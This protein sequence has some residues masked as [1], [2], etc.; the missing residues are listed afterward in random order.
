MFLIFLYIKSALA[1]G[2]PQMPAASNMTEQAKAWA[3]DDDAGAAKESKEQITSIQI[4]NE[5]IAIMRADSLILKRSICKVSSY[6]TE[7]ISVPLLRIYF[8]SSQNFVI[9]IT[10]VSKSKLPKYVNFTKAI[11]GTEFI[12]QAE[13]FIK[14]YFPHISAITREII[15]LTG[16]NHINKILFRQ[17]KTTDSNSYSMGIWHN[18]PYLQTDY[19]SGSSANDSLVSACLKLKKFK[20]NPKMIIA[21]TDGFITVSIKDH[22]L[23]DSI[24]LSYMPTDKAEKLVGKINDI[25]VI[26]DKR[27]R[28]KQELIKAANLM[29]LVQP[30]DVDFIFN[31]AAIND[32]Y[33]KIK[34]AERNIGKID[35]IIENSRLAILEKGTMKLIGNKRWIYKLELTA[36][37]FEELKK[38]H[39]DLEKYKALNIKVEPKQERGKFKITAHYY[40][41][42]KI[43]DKQ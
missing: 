29:K 3:K 19:F 13:D 4:G 40:Q 15:K 9:S 27:T 14:E 26:S 39:N 38:I 31:P 25:D 22:K 8:T 33:N 16:I 36:S 32:A 18:D 10:A 11:N 20:I 24:D 5:T 1:A 42:L 34:K 23:V 7:E 21:S 28:E 17:Q 2:F 12:S 35:K 37:S 30:F 41:F 43:G 6:K